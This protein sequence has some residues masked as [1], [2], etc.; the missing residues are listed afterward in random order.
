MTSNSV[1]SRGRRAAFLAYAGLAYLGFHAVFAWL[2]LGFLPGQ[3]G[4]TPAPFGPFAQT[5]GDDSVAPALAL[6]VNLGLVTLFGVQQLPR[7]KH[8]A[9]T[10]IYALTDCRLG[11]F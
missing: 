10:T 11:W 5:G 6:L 4:P 8:Q 1:P 2:I 9:E 7:L 3:A